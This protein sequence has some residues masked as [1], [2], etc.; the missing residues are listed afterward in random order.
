MLTR[1][2]FVIVAEIIA[3]LE[4]PTE[5]KEMAEKHAVAFKKNNPRFDRSR[6][7]TACNVN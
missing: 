2:D 3:K 6:F 4:D 5:R 7:M 1:K